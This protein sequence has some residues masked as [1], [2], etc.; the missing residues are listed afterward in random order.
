MRKG[1]HPL[2]R[3]MRVVMKNGSS[4][5][6]QSVLNRTT[7]YMLQSDT[8]THP[9]WTGEKAGLSMEDERISKLMRRFDGF[10]ATPGAKD[11]EDKETPQ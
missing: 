8:T 7:P 11:G 10:V 3:G 1:I 2:M 9:A 6:V 5:T 4:F